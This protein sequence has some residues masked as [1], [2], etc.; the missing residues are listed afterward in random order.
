[1]IVIDSSKS[2]RFGYIQGFCIMIEVLTDPEIWLFLLAISALGA[3]ARLTNYYAGQ[4]GKERIAGADVRPGR[5]RSGRVEASTRR[6][7]PTGG[8]P[9]PAKR[10]ARPDNHCEDSLRRLHDHHAIVTERAGERG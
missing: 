3:L 9:T 10:P 7:G 5:R 8:A 2:N 6:A 1:M 4:R